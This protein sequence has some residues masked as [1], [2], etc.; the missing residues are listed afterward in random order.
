MT[1]RTISTAPMN[2]VRTRLTPRYLCIRLGAPA[3]VLFDQRENGRSVLQIRHAH[4]QSADVVVDPA[5]VGAEARELAIVRLGP[6]AVPRR[7]AFLI[8]EQGRNLLS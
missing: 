2:P 5:A 3:V 7:E 8:V 6:S 4:R 1:T